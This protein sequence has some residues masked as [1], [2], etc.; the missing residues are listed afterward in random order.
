[1][2]ALPSINVANHP[3]QGRGAGGV[4]ACAGF[5]RAPIRPCTMRHDCCDALLTLFAS[6]VL[7]FLLP[8]LAHI[9]RAVLRLHMLSVW[10]SGVSHVHN[11][12]RINLTLQYSCG[13]MVAL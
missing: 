5:A 13:I 8:R 2:L 7:A 11:G 9:L 3:A 10:W 4:W 1:M 12:P 6:P